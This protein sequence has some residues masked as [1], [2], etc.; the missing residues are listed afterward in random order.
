MIRPYTGSPNSTSETLVRFCQVDVI[1][2]GS[3]LLLKLSL[4][5]CSK[6]DP[7]QGKRFLLVIALQQLLPSGL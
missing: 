1:S 6:L 7:P 2:G 3:N 4:G 5:S